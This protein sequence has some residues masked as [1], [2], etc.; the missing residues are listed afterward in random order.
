MIF[1][2]E[3]NTLNPTWLPIRVSCA[4]FAVT[5]PA[6]CERSSVSLPGPPLRKWNWKLPSGVSVIV[7]FPVP[8]LTRILPWEIVMWSAPVVPATLS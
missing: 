7:S 5:F 1:S 2:I 3:F 6:I 4:R 8:A